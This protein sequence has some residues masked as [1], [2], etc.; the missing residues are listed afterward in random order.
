METYKYIYIGNIGVELQLKD[1]QGNLNVP[2]KLEE[3]RK[4]AID[5]VSW[6]EKNKAK[7]ASNNQVASAKFDVLCIGILEKA[8]LIELD[9]YPEKEKKVIENSVFLYHN[10]Y[11]N[12]EVLVAATENVKLAVLTATEKITNILKCKSH[13]GIW[14]IL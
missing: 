14:E 1:K 12:S 11:A 3:F 8:G 10:G 7:K 13:E 9:A 2:E 4:V 6:N 5:T